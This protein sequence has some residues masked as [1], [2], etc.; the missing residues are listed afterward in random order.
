MDA[1]GASPGED[2]GSWLCSVDA[3]GVGKTNHYGV[4]GEFRV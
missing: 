1:S 2:M 3:G 4:T